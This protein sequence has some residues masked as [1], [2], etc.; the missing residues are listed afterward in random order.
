[1]FPWKGNV[2][3]SSVDPHPGHH[4]QL[5]EGREEEEVEVNVIP[6]LFF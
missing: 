2:P 5:E 1:M 4:R 3:P 6:L